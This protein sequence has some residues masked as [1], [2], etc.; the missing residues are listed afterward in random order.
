MQGGGEATP[1][2]LYT[3]LAPL[4]KKGYESNPK[5][6]YQ[7]NSWDVMVDPSGIPK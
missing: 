3:V 2:V 6:I 5:E 7:A 4:P 1:G